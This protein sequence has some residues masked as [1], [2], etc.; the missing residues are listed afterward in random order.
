MDKGGR[1]SIDGIDIHSSGLHIVLFA[2]DEAATDFIRISLH[3]P[4]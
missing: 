4:L 1:Q 3:P 2:N